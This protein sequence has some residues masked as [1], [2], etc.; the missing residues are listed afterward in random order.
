MEV[1]THLRTTNPA[2]SILCRGDYTGHPVV[3]LAQCLTPLFCAPCRMS[4]YLFKTIETGK[5]HI[6]TLGEKKG[7]R[8]IMKIEN[9]SFGSIP[10]DGETFVK[11]VIIENSSIK[12]RKKA[13]SKNTGTYLGI[14][15]FHRT[16][17]SPGIVSILLSERTIV[18]VSR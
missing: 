16:K 15:H 1:V 2:R 7:K 3:H 5:F 12:K 6:F 17:I 18:R 8:F 14:L 13:E 11:N 4:W 10:I 9:L